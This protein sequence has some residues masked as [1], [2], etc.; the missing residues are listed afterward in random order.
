MTLLVRKAN[1]E[2][3]CILRFMATISMRNNVGMFSL[4]AFSLIPRV[5]ERFQWKISSFLEIN[6]NVVP[7][8]TYVPVGTTMRPGRRLMVG[9]KEE[10]EVVWQSWTERH[11]SRKRIRIR[12]ATWEAGSRKRPLPRFL[13]LLF[14]DYKIMHFFVVRIEGSAS[15]QLEASQHLYSP[16]SVRPPSGRSS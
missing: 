5:L 9:E 4:V 3:S 14:K 2:A 6:W 15:D 11:I 8:R 16:V 1:F 10:E 12:T 13:N 7:D